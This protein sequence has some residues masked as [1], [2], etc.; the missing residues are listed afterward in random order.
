MPRRTLYRKEFDKRAE[1]MAFV[2][3]IDA[4]LAEAFGV[5]E[6]TLNNWKEKHP[7]FL[8]SIKRGREIADHRVTKALYR[9]ALGYSHPAVKILTVSGGSG[10]GSSVEQVPYV[11][12]YPP[13]TT[14]AIFWLKNRQPK[15]WRDKHEVEHSADGS[16]ASLIGSAF[17]GAASE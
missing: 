11:E 13:D 10:E 1:D 2:G 4:E 17:K 3:A 9:R 8:E 7:S 6:T 5:S 16:L 14:A 12:R 15:R